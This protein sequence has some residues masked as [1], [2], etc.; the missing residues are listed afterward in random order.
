MAEPLKK[1]FRKTL[2]KE[3]LTDIVYHFSAVGKAVGVLKD[4]AIKASP[5]YGEEQEFGNNKFY[6]ISTTSTRDPK[7][8]FANLIKKNDIPLACFNLNGRVINQ[9]YKSVR[10]DYFSAL[11]NSGGED[12]DH[13]EDE[14]EDRVVMDDP[15]LKPLSKYVL[16]IHVEYNDEIGDRYYRYLHDKANKLNIP[17]YFYTEEK[18]FSSQ[19]KDKAVNIEEVISADKAGEEDVIPAIQRKPQIGTKTLLALSIYDDD[20]LRETL[21]N[22]LSAIEGIELILKKAGHD[23]LDKLFNE[24]LQDLNSKIESSKGSG[25]VSSIEQKVGQ[26]LK[27]T[28]EL[29]KDVINRTILHNFVKAYKKI[30]ADNLKEFISKRLNLED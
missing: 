7:S 14:M 4:D 30:G 24:S 21:K 17:I 10:V 8:G 11:R 26:E 22:N 19:N 20:N 25:A 15:E 9:R 6:F 27:M 23:S 28:K 12:A 29:Y 3:G 5:V 13:Y 1:I 18:Y 2:L 16:E